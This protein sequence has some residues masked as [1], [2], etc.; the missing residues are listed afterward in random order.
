MCYVNSLKL[1]LQY[2]TTGKRKDFIEAVENYVM[3]D[4]LIGC[5]PFRLQGQQSYS[6]GQASATF[7]V[8][9]GQTSSIPR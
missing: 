8:L 4:G 1:K 5:S 3:P 9:N 6:V 2:N 7:N